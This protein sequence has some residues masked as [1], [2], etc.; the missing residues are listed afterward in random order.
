MENTNTHK[1]FYSMLILSILGLVLSFELFGLLGNFNLVQALILAFMAAFLVLLYK[2]HKIGWIMALIYFSW[3]LF[4]GL[5]F[6]LVFYSSLLRNADANWGG[7][8]SFIMPLPN[9]IIATVALF[10][11]LRKKNRQLFFK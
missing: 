2:G 6:V 10:I 3:K 7:Y 1:L 4:T 8:Y 5:S 9:L 11:L